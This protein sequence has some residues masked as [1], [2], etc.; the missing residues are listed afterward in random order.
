MLKRFPET[1]SAVVFL[2]MHLPS[3][4]VFGGSMWGSIPFFSFYLHLK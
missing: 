1:M 3:N 4:L 2:K